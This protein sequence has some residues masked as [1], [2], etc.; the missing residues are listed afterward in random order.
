MLPYRKYI[1]HRFKN[2]RKHLE[3]FQYTRDAEDLHRFRVEFKKIRT[4]Y[5]VCRHS[6]PSLKKSKGFKQL[7]KL[8]AASGIL[9]DEAI[10]RDLLQQYNLHPA[11]QYPE[12]LVEKQEKRIQ[13]FI[14]RSNY[15]LSKLPSR[16]KKMS[17][18]ADN[19]DLHCLESYTAEK[20]HNIRQKM[21]HPDTESV[22]HEIRKEIKH[23]KYI[24]EFEPRCIP[25]QIIRQYDAIQNRIGSWHD[26]LVLTDYLE[27][28]YPS[29]RKPINK[30]LEESTQAAASIKN[31]LM[32]LATSKQR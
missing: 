10:I 27:K 5:S 30:L 24:S 9:R 17:E 19:L 20:I 14:K 32:T 15:L 11:E 28:N 4:F 25:V 12:E 2:I 22:L 26:K 31:K 29:N 21:A 8:Y 18:I 16:D 23:L 6:V 3:R 7:K 13:K 1:N